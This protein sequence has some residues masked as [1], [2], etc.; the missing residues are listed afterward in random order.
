[1]NRSSLPP[2][3]APTI[4]LSNTNELLA[5][6]LMSHT[7][8]TAAS[9][10]SP[11]SSNF[12]LIINNAL[13]TYRKRTKKDLRAHPLAAQIQSCDTPTAILSVLQQQ[14]QGLDR[15]RSTDERWTKWLDPTVNVL[16]AF[17]GI[18]GASVSLVCLNK[19]HLFEICFLIF[20]WQLFSPASVIFAGVGIL[21]SVRI[22]LLALRGP[23]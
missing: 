8:P 21:L 23:L 7:H 2:T 10:S 12:Q 5:L 17:S 16:F 13:D 20:M 4:V 9:S 1:V 6:T 22:S 14:A 18:L 3:L 19:M 15:S 11:P